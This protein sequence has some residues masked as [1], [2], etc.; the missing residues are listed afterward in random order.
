MS[1]FRIWGTFFWTRVGV[2]LHH[3]H[4][5]KFLEFFLDDVNICFNPSTLWNLRMY[6]FLK[7]WTYFET[8]EH[9]FEFVNILLN[10]INIFLYC[11]RQYFLNLRTYFFLNHE[12]YLLN[13]FQLE[14]WPHLNCFKKW[15]ENGNERNFVFERF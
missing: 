1:T 3:V 12:Y 8:G 15:T 10:L 2:F 5:L 6:F 9:Y 14:Y 13:F 11:T 7:P 4:I